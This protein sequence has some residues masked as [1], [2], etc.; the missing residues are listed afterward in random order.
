[1]KITQLSH[2]IV[3]AFGWRR[4]LIAFVAVTVSVLA[5]APF[6]LW[7]ILFLTFPVAV[8]LIDGAAAK[9]GSGIVS[10]AITG[11]C[12]GFGYFVAG[13]YWIGHAFLVDAKTFGWLLPFAVIGLPLYLSIYTAF[14]FA[15][16]RALWTRGP[17]RILTLA[18]T[19]TIAEW[20]RGH[21]LTGFPWNTFGYALTGPL[22]LAQTSALTG[23]WGLTFL[24]VAVFASPA[25]LADDRADT[26]RPWLPLVASVGVLALLAIFG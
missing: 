20:L 7:P 10:A 14:G 22:V 1:M 16:A 13:L 19:L 9:Q 23:I 3:L 25:A 24:A 2:P 11:W 6:D 4:A 15:L 8:W 12:F 26:P 21:L 18:L 17:I 5:L